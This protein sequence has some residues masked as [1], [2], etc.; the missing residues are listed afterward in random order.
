[1]RAED[2]FPLG[3]LDRKFRRQPYPDM[4]YEGAIKTAMVLFWNIGTPDA[5]NLY[6]QLST[7][8]TRMGVDH[9]QFEGRSMQSVTEL[10]ELWRGKVTTL[11][12]WFQKAGAK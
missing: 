7:V 8:H 4:T 11:L 1:M 9:A 6:G 5:K 10:N 12:T 3:W 2:F